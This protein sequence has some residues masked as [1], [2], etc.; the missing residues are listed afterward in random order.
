MVH[1]PHRRGKKLHD[2]ISDQWIVIAPATSTATEFVNSNRARFAFSTTRNRL[3]GTSVTRVLL[4][5]YHHLHEVLKVLG[6][7]VEE[8]LDAAREV[9]DGDVV[10]AHVTA[11]SSPHTETPRPSFG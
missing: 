1:H 6:D 11:P 5:D 10:A 2:A 8:R 3:S 9:A 7:P 4:L